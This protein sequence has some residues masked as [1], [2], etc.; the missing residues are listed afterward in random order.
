MQSPLIR[1][2]S[3]GLRHQP[4]H[5]RLPL[6]PVLGQRSPQR[7]RSGSLDTPEVK[8][9]NEEEGRPR[10]YSSPEHRPVP[11]EM[12]EDKEEQHKEEEFEMQG[13]AISLSKHFWCYI[14]DI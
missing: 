3:P 13:I 11:E 5:R 1:S 2:G 14:C 10:S 12:M 8:V 6:T 7:S 4:R 9:A